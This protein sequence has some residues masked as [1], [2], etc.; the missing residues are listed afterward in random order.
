VGTTIKLWKVPD[1][2]KQAEIRAEL[3]QGLEFACGEAVWS[4]IAGPKGDYV[5][6]LQLGERQIRSARLANPRLSFLQRTYEGSVG[7]LIECP[8]RLDGPSGVLLSYLSL[9]Q[10][11]DPPDSDEVPDFID[12]TLESFEITNRP[13]DLKLNFSQGRV[14]RCFCAEVA[15][16]REPNV[17]AQ[18]MADKEMRPKTGQ[19]PR[20]NWSFWAPD[21]ALV[22]GPS[23][24]FL[25]PRPVPEAGLRQRLREVEALDDEII[26][27]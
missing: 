1:V 26:D 12:L 17:R 13:W 14:L 19:A 10:R 6:S 24:E 27:E 2:E 23:G 20:N 4:A 11:V 8:W 21:H 15:Q 18:S 5:L 22:I 25:Q 16:G 7:F 9:L 3:E